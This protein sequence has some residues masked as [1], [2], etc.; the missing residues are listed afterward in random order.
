MRLRFFLEHEVEVVVVYSDWLIGSL[1]VFCQFQ[2][3]ETLPERICWM[4]K[5]CT[6]SLVGGYE[7]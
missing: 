1:S 5:V 7:Y 6:A 3:V 2:T 4:I